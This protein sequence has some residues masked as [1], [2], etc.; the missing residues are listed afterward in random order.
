[1]LKLSPTNVSCSYAGKIVHIEKMSQVVLLW[2]MSHKRQASP[3]SQEAQE[4]AV[5][6]CLR[7]AQKKSVE[8]IK[9]SG[10]NIAD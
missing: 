2:M 6:S 7:F 5:R 8:G 3:L 1:V 4:S 10:V 9:D